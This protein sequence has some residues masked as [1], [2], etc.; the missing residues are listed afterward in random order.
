MRETGP[1]QRPKKDHLGEQP[2]AAQPA[3]VRRAA[4]PTDTFSSPRPGVRGLSERV[5]K[6]LR[7]EDLEIKKPERHRM[8]EGGLGRKS[9]MYRHEKGSTETETHCLVS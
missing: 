1:W 6:V 4:E 3:T 8:G 5:Y 7:K 9:K 2:G